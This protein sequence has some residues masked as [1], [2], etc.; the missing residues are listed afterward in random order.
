MNLQPID[1]VSCRQPRLGYMHLCMAFHE[2]RS[3]SNEYILARQVITGQWLV[4]YGGSYV[5]LADS[6]FTIVQW[7]ELPK[8]NH[9]DF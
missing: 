5:L 6:G 2:D 7:M 9:Y 4:V 8:L 3:D 1:A